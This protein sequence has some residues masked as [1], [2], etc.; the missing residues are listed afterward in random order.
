MNDKSLILRYTFSPCHRSPEVT[1]LCLY[2]NWKLK[3]TLLRE[4]KYQSRRKKWFDH[5]SLFFFYNW[6]GV[7]IVK[8]HLFSICTDLLSQVLLLLP[9]FK[10][11]NLY[12]FF[13]KEIRGSTVTFSFSLFFFNQINVQALLTYILLMFLGITIFVR[14]CFTTVSSITNRGKRWKDIKLINLLIR[15]KTFLS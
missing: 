13:W 14:W 3:K 11:C 8:L 1:T 15:N 12:S 6:Y 4:E 9:V 7:Q 2:N 10:L 5:I